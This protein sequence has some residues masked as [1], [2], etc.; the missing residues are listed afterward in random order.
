[1]NKKIGI[2]IAI[3]FLVAVVTFFTF[4]YVPKTDMECDNEAP[5]NQVEGLTAESD[6][7]YVE[8]TWDTVECAE[9]YIIYKDDGTGWTRG[10]S[11]PSISGEYYEQIG[12]YGY[13]IKRTADTTF[14]DRN[15]LPGA[16]Y[17]YSIVAISGDYYFDKDAVGAVE[18]GR[19]GERSIQVAIIAGE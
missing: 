6:G 13:P 5:P 4:Y 19:E 12:E 3:I 14:V 17:K 10:L 18:E 1:M 9:E 2:L 7:S 8:L 16:E 11:G 15:V